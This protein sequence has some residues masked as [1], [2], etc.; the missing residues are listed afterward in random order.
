MSG[1]DAHPQHPIMP[2]EA[3]TP[4]IFDR[5]A[6]AV[7]DHVSQA[8]FFCLCVLI[9]VVWAPT[10]TL[11]DLDTWQLIINTLTTIIT[12]LLV[13]LLQNTQ[14]RSDAAMQQKLNAIADGLADLMGALH[15]DERPL[16]RDRRELL[17]AVGL[18]NHE[19]SD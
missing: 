2:S 10:L 4:S 13:A 11:T 12:F 16:A 1:N 3:G 6:T 18:E 9:V 14:K 17:A 7:G 19:S 8:W 15:S 5:F